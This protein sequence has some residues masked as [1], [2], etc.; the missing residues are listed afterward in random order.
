MLR[1]QQQSRIHGIRN[2]LREGLIR[3]KMGLKG[4]ADNT[5]PPRSRKLATE[6]DYYTEF[7]GTNSYSN[8]SIT[9]GVYIPG[10]RQS[11]AEYTDQVGSCISLSDSYSGDTEEPGIH[12]ATANTDVGYSTLGHNGDP[13]STNTSASV[14]KQI[15]RTEYRVFVRRASKRTRWSP[16]PTQKQRRGSVSYN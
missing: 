13:G 15:W 5:H 10:Y 16:S 11:A 6:S 7:N 1:H 2:R 14:I 9:P 4:V 8:H 12:G 3:Q